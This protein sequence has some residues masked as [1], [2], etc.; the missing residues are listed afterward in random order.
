MCIYLQLF[1]FVVE[2]PLQSFAHGTGLEMISGCSAVLHCRS[3]GS[4]LIATSV[5][6]PVMV[7]M[8]AGRRCVQLRFAWFRSTTYSDDSA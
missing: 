4:V 6:T 8:T 1:L 3:G 7:P 5:F 2:F